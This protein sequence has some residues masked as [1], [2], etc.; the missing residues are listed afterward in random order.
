MTT[1]TPP[2]RPGWYPDPEGGSRQ[3]YWDGTQWRVQPRS[4]KLEERRKWWA[5]QQAR[6]DEQAEPVSG[7]TDLD[8]DDDEKKGL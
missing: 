1:P 5:E 3:R 7:V 4:P 8:A 6:V 2:T